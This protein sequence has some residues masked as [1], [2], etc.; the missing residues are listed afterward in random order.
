MREKTGRR[1]RGALLAALGV[2]GAAALVACGSDKPA[3]AD[4]PSS[5]EVSSSPPS[6]T[7][8]TAAPV[9]SP[10][11]TPKGTGEP[12]VPPPPPPPTASKGDAGRPSSAPSFSPAPSVPD[13]PPVTPE[14]A[15][16]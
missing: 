12:Y 10:G 6:P 9:R 14:P 4:A 16:T 5:P 1:I 8:T 15:G 7:S 11:S 3:P 2:C 13:E